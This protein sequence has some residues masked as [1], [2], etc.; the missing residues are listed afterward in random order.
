MGPVD[1]CG[2]VA[3]EERGM[4]GEIDLAGDDLVCD[5]AEVG[6]AEGD[7]GADHEAGGDEKSEGEGDLADYECVAPFG[8]SAAGAG[9][10][11]PLAQAIL[12][13]TWEACRAGRRPKRMAETQDAMRR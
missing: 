4:V 8:L 3:D 1:C 9:C 7:E 2:S 13:E 5:E 10:G 11:G 12:G 6:V